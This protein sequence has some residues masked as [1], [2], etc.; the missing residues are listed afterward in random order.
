MRVTSDSTSDLIR[1]GRHTSAPFLP[2]EDTKRRQLSASQEDISHQEAE[3]KGRGGRGQKQRNKKSDGRQQ[4][5]KKGERR[6]RESRI[7]LCLEGRSL[8]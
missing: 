1:R 3:A 7:N 2:C 5:R 8:M 4:R 6:G